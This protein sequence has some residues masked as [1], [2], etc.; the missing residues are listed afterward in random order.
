M[1]R[2]LAVVLLLCS[3]KLT[4]EVPEGYYDATEGLT[5]KDLKAALNDIIKDHVQFSYSS[6]WDILKETDRDPDN[7]DNVILIYTGW[8]VDAAQ[9][10]NFG[11]GWN[12]EHVW[13]VSHGD[14]G[15]A[16]GAGT[17][18]H[19]IRPSDISVNS[20]RGNKDFDNG[21]VEYIDPDGPTGCYH[22][23]Y[24]W[25]PR[26][27][28]KGDV[29]RMIF[30]MAVRYEGISGDP[31]LEL[32]DYAPSSP[33]NEPYH[34]VL[35][36]LYEWHIN[37]PPDE[38]ER[39]RNN[40]IYYDYQQNRN[41]F[42]DYPEFAGLLWFPTEADQ[43]YEITAD[44]YLVTNFPNPFNPETTIEFT[45]S[46]PSPVSI[47]VYNLNGQKVSNLV[48][49]NFNRG[50]HQI[51]WNTNEETGIKIGSGIYFY[52]LITNSYSATRK[53]ILLK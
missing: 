8:S 15:T 9:E 48:S 45:I 44:A 37:D 40:I 31:D 5:G 35:S 12:R 51:I 20:A 16:M 25:E 41:P 22:T 2:Y 27:E 53:M 32:V 24:T 49:N 17:D 50:T 46:E 21:G 28:D 38:F 13:A 14:F 4:A 7:S 19:H 29:A 18:V 30:Y 47:T 52:R 43:D 34:G 3:A 26:D 23:A 39:T 10:Y 6:T 36:T 42:I 1:L 33:N 11:N